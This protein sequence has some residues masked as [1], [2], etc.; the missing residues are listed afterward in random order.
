MVN[1][2]TDKYKTSETILKINK[3]AIYF[4]NMVSET[5]KFIVEEGKIVWGE[6]W[7][8]PYCGSHYASTKI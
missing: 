3:T 7:F 5:E 4:D 2:L 8:V 1:K 6:R